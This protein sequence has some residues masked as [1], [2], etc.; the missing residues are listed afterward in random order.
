MLAR[1]VII[2]LF[3]IVLLRISG[4]RSFGLGTSFDNVIIILLGA[5]LSRG[6]VGA[7]E[8]DLVLISSTVIAVFHRLIGT[9]VATSSVASGWIEG[10]EI[11][12][13]E[14]G[15][16]IATSLRR[17]QLSKDHIF[18]AIRQYT[19]SNDLSDIDKIFLEKNGTFTLI[20]KMNTGTVGHKR[21]G[22]SN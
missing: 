1:S 11:L 2:F 21:T 6:I 16:F 4:R 14:K 15:I 20:K 5:I 7:S 10:D 13:F 3:A 8:L 12:L 22:S 18:Q 9:L 19:M 17:A